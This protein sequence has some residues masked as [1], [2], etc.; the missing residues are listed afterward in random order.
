MG[1]MAFQ[2]RY[3]SVRVSDV[4]LQVTTHI[5][6]QPVG[7]GYEEAQGELVVGQVHGVEAII[8]RGDALEGHLG[9]SPRQ[10]Q[11]GQHAV[12]VAGFDQY[13]LAVVLGYV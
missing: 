12:H 7:V 10:V 13:E 6:G 9:Q 11:V 5:L 2:I 1:L 8:D 3:R 4:C